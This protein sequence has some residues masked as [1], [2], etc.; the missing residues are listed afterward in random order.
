MIADEITVKIVFMCNTR[1]EDFIE[2][3]Y[4]RK[5]YSL[6]GDIKIT[7]KYVYPFIQTRSKY[8][9]KL[10]YLLVVIISHDFNKFL[11][12]KKTFLSLHWLLAYSRLTFQFYILMSSKRKIA[13]TFR[14]LSISV[15][16]QVYS[17]MR[18]HSVMIVRF[19]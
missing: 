9:N 4:G 7:L 13:L 16:D 11:G 10:L 3:L 2:T 15:I 5:Y 8:H 19:K 1:Q 17:C 6:L 12:A 14:K 18:F